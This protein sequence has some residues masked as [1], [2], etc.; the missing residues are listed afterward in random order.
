MDIVNTYLHKFYP[1]EIHQDSL[2]TSMHIYP[3][4][5]CKDG[6]SLSIQAG[7]GMASSPKI[8]F[9]ESYTDVEVGACSLYE[10]LFEDYGSSEPFTS[11]PIYSY[12]PVKLVEQ[13]ILKHG[14]IK[15]DE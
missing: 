5:I 8:S 9:A 10:P 4:L 15:E 1:K 11:L 13:I 3:K 14:G 12:V 6:F 7:Y 2:L